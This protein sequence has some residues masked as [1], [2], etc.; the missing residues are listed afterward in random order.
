[1]GTAQAAVSH[2]RVVLPNEEVRW[3]RMRARSYPED[4]DGSGQT[5]G[6]L[7]DIT[8]L[9]SAEAEA[10]VGQDPVGGVLS[11]TTIVTLAAEEPPQESV[12]LSVTTLVPRG[13]DTAS[14]G[15]VPRT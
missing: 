8:D 13:K 10:A 2:V 1:M 15:V 4:R 14:F 6:I 11:A 12:T 3:L 7:L 5:S 9:K